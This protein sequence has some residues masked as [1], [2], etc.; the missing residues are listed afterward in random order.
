TFAQLQN[1][2]ANGNANVGG[3]YVKQGQ[4]AQ[5]VRSVGLFGGGTDPVNKVLGYESQALDDFIAK[6]N[7]TAEEAAR[8]RDAVARRK[9]DP[10]LTEEEQNQV[11]TIDRR[12]ALRAALVLRSE[13]YRRLRDIRSLVISSVN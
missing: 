6:N 5:S 3:D 8:I 2:L 10:P 7:L 1:A 13:E 11:D 9:M 4:V 12:A